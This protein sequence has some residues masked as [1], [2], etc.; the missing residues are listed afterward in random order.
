[1]SNG[2]LPA[3]IQAN[4]HHDAINRVSR[5]FSAGNFDR[6][7]EPI[8]NA[9]RSGA[10]QVHL[11]THDDSISVYDDGH[12]IADSNSIFSFGLSN[13][14]HHQPQQEYPAGMGISS[15]AKCRQVTIQSRSAN[16]DAA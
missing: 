13:W 6:I 7:N 8:Q 14:S 12:G 3:T 2:H 5:F 15:L 11:S 1:M 9:R 16:S 4:I 10:S